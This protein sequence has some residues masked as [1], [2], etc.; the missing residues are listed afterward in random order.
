M[1]NTR[2]AA[3]LLLAGLVLAAIGLAG[4]E[5]RAGSGRINAVW[6]VHPATGEAV[7]CG[8][9]TGLTQITYLGATDLMNNC[10]A[11]YRAQGYDRAPGP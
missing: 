3:V 6:L 9:Y 8:P 4:C 7:R 1:T 11:D 10:V 2:L 5:G